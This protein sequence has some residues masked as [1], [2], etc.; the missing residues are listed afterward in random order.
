MAT[1]REHMAVDIAYLLADDG[2]AGTTVTIDEV[3]VDVIRQPV[4]QEEYPPAEP[5]LL[6]IRDRFWVLASDLG[7]TPELG[8]QMDI[9]GD[10]WQVDDVGDWGVVL[11]LTLIRYVS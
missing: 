11:L 5:G 8:Q 6:V 7:Y 3:D 4:G 10:T 2:E 9:D 1:A